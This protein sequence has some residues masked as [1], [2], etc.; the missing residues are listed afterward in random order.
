[1]ADEIE[2]SKIVNIGA[3]TQ[4]AD[5][6]IEQILRI[7]KALQDL[8][9]AQSKIGQ[10][11]ALKD[12][13]EVTSQLQKATQSLTDAI[14]GTAKAQK[15]ANDESIKSEKLKKAEAQSAEALAKQQLAEVKLRE[16]NEKAAAREA[17]AIEALS[18]AKN[19]ELQAEGNVGLSQA[20]IS[21]KKKAE[22]A[23][24]DYAKSLEF[25]AQA[26]RE[27][28]AAMQSASA[29]GNQRAQLVTDPQ[30]IEESVQGVVKYQDTLESLTGTLDENQKLQNIYKEEISDV[31]LQLK[32]LEKNTT[33][34]ERSTDAY[35]NKVALLNTRQAELKKD[36][37]ELSSII[38]NQVKEQNNAVGSLDRMNARLE[39]L[40]RAYAKLSAMEKANPLGR[41]LNA[42]I[43]ALNT[44]VL[45]EES[46][47]G[48]SQK[49]VGNYANGIVKA[50]GNAFSAV[51]KIAY[52]LPGIGIA[53][54]F[55][56]IGEGI[57]SALEKLDLFGS[58]AKR[59]QKDFA[60]SMKDANAE[61]GKQVGEIKALYAVTQD[62]NQS[63]DDRKDAT[64]RLL[65]INK[66]NNE[67]TGEHTSLLVNQ[68]GVLGENDAAINKLSESL[69]K[70]AKTK[71]YLGVIEKAYTKVIEEQTKGLDDQFNKFENVVLDIQET[72]NK[73]VN[74]ISGTP[75]IPKSATQLFSKNKGE[76]DAKDYLKAVTDIFLNGL[77]SG[78][79]DLGGIFGGGKGNKDAEKLA[80]QLRKDALE[81]FK[82]RQGLLIEEQKAISNL[83]GA[84]LKIRIDAR[85]KQTELEKELI[86]RVADFELLKANQTADEK[87][88]IDEKRRTDLIN[89]ESQRYVGVLQIRVTTEAAINA[90]IE[91]LQA[92]F[93]ERELKA[94]EEAEKEKQRIKTRQ[95][96]T[97]A[98]DVERDLRFAEDKYTAELVALSK[99]FEQGKIKKE[100]YEKEKLRIENEAIAESIRIQIAYYRALILISDLPADKQK[101]AIKKLHDLEIQSAKLGIKTV[102]DKAD[103]EIEI[104][105]KKNEALKQLATELSGL[106]FDLFTAGID[107]QKNAIQDQIDALEA[108]KQKEIEVQNQITQ[109]TTDRA[110]NIAIIEART[111]AQRE[112]LELRQRKLQQERA[113]FEK[114]QSIASILQSTAIAVVGAL[115]A[116]P[117]TP[118]NIALAAIVGAL[119]A[120][121]IARVLVT[122]IPKYFR[123]KNVGNTD[124]YEGPAWVDDGGKPELI[125]RE[126]GSMEVGSNKPRLTFV[127]SKDQVYP[128]A[129][130]ELIKRSMI[131][132]KGALV[133]YKTI[134]IQNN[135]NDKLD[136]TMRHGFKMLNNTIKNKRETHIHIQRPIR[137]WISNGQSSQEFLD[138]L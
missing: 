117:W 113:R 68:N 30:V 60:D 63:I 14:N 91:K 86:N 89:A 18:K 58:T 132:S 51:R 87:I 137:K 97:L 128:D 123:G 50:A 100:G 61:I 80:E 120:A 92:E 46:A 131:N 83:T 8:V 1:M 31:G 108:R 99:S 81:L 73:V 122:P 34:A 36:S 112:Q 70:Q 43:T 119:G 107:R 126:D 2:I 40:N 76:S 136:M 94:T 66:E 95:I 115:G 134:V 19:A 64:K 16:A 17:A 114:A 93:H 55:S 5:K 65:E 88:L 109:S 49:N 82:Y 127:G 101:E 21:E 32:N 85:N 129:K 29:S 75:F 102:Q 24:I 11:S 33:A 48:K 67:K 78:D 59:A 56:L 90:E 74:K 13:R 96:D 44:A 41:S 10:I 22:Q 3:V 133:D 98:S 106:T 35:K 72:Y 7:D 79:L 28:D 9:V 84:A 38:S 135:Q 52:I 62:T 124:S 12:L 47:L 45:A 116:K 54:I 23:A 37:K 15:V 53:G 6:T 57:I 138:S 104:E 39:L 103:K 4:D 20:A 130:E 69:I 26:Q 125:V 27:L 121:Q 25:Q 111:A 118:A 77:K 105:K 42:E 71:A 110:N